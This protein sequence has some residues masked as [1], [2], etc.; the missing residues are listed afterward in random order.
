MKRPLRN[1]VFGREI[2][3]I[4]TYM[5]SYEPKITKCQKFFKNKEK[6]NICPSFKFL[7]HSVNPN[8]WDKAL[9]LLL[10]FLLIPY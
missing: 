6:L 2:S 4:E 10:L 3:N 9:A 8:T 7:V 1:H 5:L